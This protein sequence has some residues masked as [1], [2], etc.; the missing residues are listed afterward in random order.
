MSI[1]SLICELLQEHDCV[2]VPGLGGFIVH[3]KKATI[4]EDGSIY[5]PEKTF[6]FNI[7][8]NV[9]DGLLIHELSRRENISFK[10]AKAAVDSFVN[11]ALAL[12]QQKEYVYLGRLGTLSAD[13]EGNIQFNYNKQ[14]FDF[15][16]FFGLVPVKANTIRKQE[17]SAHHVAPCLE[18]KEEKPKRAKTKQRRFFVGYA[19][20]AILLLA[21]ITSLVFH[22][23][24][25]RP[26]HINNASLAPEIDSSLKQISQ[27]TSH[28]SSGTNIK[29][30]EL[31][32]SNNSSLEN[33]HMSLMQNKTDENELQGA[34]KGYFIIAG[35]FTKP[36]NAEKLY[37]ELQEEI[38]DKTKVVKL[39]RNQF[40][41]VGFFASNEKQEALRIL[42]MAKQKEE[43]AWLLR[44]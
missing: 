17:L 32:T 19:A 20:A 6:S 3:R 1:A 38:G 10:E 8:L 42:Q 13:A 34:L 9:N 21:I 4:S 30:S 23:L 37:S 2:I 5:P 28:D 14:T 24:L 22:F 31:A 40:T 29:S 7:R 11:T 36:Q 18:E 43:S 35:A 44:L 27:K 25:P 16:E 41:L 15:D 39:S 33:A 26:A 12:L